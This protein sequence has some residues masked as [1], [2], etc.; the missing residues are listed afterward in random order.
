MSLRALLGWTPTQTITPREG[1][2]WT[3][4]T[5]SEWDYTERN[6]A[7]ALDEIDR[8]T[9]GGCGGD[10]T[11]ELTDKPPYE[12]DGD[13]HY[14]RSTQLWCRRCVAQEKLHRQLAKS[15][16]ELRDTPADPFPAARRIAWQRLPIPTAD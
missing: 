2:G 12:D 15:D 11:V 14:H 5:E 9:C 6:I 10:L 1:G 16:E 7:V 3:V 8:Q 13:G 4:T